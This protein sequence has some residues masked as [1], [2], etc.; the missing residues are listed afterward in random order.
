M[1]ASSHFSWPAPERRPRSPWPG[2]CRAA[3]GLAGG[4]SASEL[5]RRKSELGRDCQVTEGRWTQTV[6]AVAHKPPWA[7]TAA[8]RGQRLYLSQMNAKEIELGTHFCKSQR[9]ARGISSGQSLKSSAH[10]GAPWTKPR[11]AHARM[12]RHPGYGPL[13][14]RPP[15]GLRLGPG[16]A[17]AHRLASSSAS[18]GFPGKA[19]ATL[20]KE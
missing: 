12:P 19:S 10:S 18:E 15:R 13:G 11:S 7:L 2:P 6:T 16:T 9:K 5:Q 14:Q 4:P 3:G 1:A 17:A 20:F 8:L